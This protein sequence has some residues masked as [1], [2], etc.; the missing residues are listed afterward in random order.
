L[1][2]RP[3]AAPYPA[4]SADLAF[5]SLIRVPAEGLLEVEDVLVLEDLRVDLSALAP[6]GLR[7]NAG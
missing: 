6:S 7:T 1:E 2:A 3:P 5:W 4:A